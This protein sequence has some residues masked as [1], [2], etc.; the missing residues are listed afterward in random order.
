MLGRE[1]DD[2]IAVRDPVGHVIERFRIH[3]ASLAG[4]GVATSSY[5]LRSTARW[6][7][8][9]VICERPA[10]FIRFASL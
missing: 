5:F 3:A 1:L 2:G 4:E 10:T 8:A 6:S 9:F 7:C